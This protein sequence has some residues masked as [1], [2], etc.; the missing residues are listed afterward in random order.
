[1]SKSSNILLPPCTYQGGK[2]RV[3]S[4]IV[5]YIINHEL[6]H[7]NTKIYDICCGSGAMTIE[8]INRG[9][10]PNNII[11]LD[12]SSWGKF[13]QSIG[14]GTFNISKW[15]WWCNQ[16]PKN[17]SLVQGFLEELCKDDA[18]IDEEYKYILLQ[19]GSFGGKQIWKENNVWKNTSFRSYWQ[20]TETSR[21]RSPVNPMQPSIENLQ[22]R[23]KT[24]AEKCTGLTCIHDDINSILPIIEQDKS[25]DSII[26]IDPPYSNTTGY[27]FK[28]NL[29]NFL[30]ELFDVTLRPIYVSE[31]EKIAEEA[32]LLNFN[33]AKGGISGKKQEKNEEWLNVYR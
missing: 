31:K 19:S 5:D 29:S 7:P 21:R 17:K 6:I 11:M 27:G 18:N 14:N 24:I 12:K 32:I 15:D 13:W 30:S 16:V 8:W 3:S 28:F 2:Q 26:Y 9:V 4:E 10:S 23:V 22:E 1:M 25:D 33:G 20:P